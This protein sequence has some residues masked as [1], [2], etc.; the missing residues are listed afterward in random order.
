M[1][2]ACAEGWRRE[3]GKGS[4]GQD[5]QRVHQGRQDSRGHCVDGCTRV[6][7]SGGTDGSSWGQAWM[8]FL[9]K[10]IVPESTEGKEERDWHWR[11]CII[12]KFNWVWFFSN[13]IA[14]LSFSYT[15][16][17]VRLQNSGAVATWTKSWWRCR[18]CNKKHSVSFTFPIQKLAPSL[19]WKHKSWHHRHVFPHKNQGGPNDFDSQLGRL[20]KY[21]WNCV[22]R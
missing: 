16:F 12:I 8:E 13:Y 15:N 4:S 5:V 21:F 7:D 19:Q 9:D 10:F 20:T 11:L 1:A 22:V 14:D 3:S 2:R 6:Q 17:D 18:I